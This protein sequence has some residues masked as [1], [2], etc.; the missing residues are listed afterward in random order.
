MY[1]LNCHLPDR[2]GEL[3]NFYSDKY[4]YTKVGMVQEALAMYFEQKNLTQ[5]ILDAVSSDPSKLGSFASALGL[6]SSVK[7]ESKEGGHGLNV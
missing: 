1:R 2:F 3:L 7:G 4:G 5:K 6:D